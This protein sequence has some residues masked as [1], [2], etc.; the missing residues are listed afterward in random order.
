M[1]LESKKIAILTANGVTEK[2]VSFFQRALIQ[3]RCFPKIIGVGNRLIT[4]WT[5]TDWGHNF[6]VDVNISEALGSD[7]DILVIP[8][9][10]RA[11]NLLQTTEHTKRILNAFMQGGKPVVV[12]NEAAALFSFFGLTVDDCAA[13]RTVEM[14][15]DDG[16]FEAAVTEAIDWVENFG[17]NTLDKQ[18]A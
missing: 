14:N 2:E 7:Y 4:A 17:Q 6:A 9:G 15:A 5:G 16:D 10:E 3:K 1:T 13:V 12:L 8:G 18:A 11:V